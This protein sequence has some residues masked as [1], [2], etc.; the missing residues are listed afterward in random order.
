MVTLE[1][2]TRNYK[3]QRFRH[4][5]FLGV[6]RAIRAEYPRDFKRIANIPFLKLGI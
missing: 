4:G 6:R 3:T 5:Y 2:K 1:R